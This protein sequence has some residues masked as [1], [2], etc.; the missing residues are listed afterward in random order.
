MHT[1]AHDYSALNPNQQLNVLMVIEICTID[2]AKQSTS[3]VGGALG[4]WGVQIQISTSD[5]DTT[6]QWQSL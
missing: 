5:I 6:R 2:G 3:T 4:V 1:T